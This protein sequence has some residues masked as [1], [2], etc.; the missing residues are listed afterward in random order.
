MKQKIIGLLVLTA[1]LLGLTACATRRDSSA[2]GAVYE[3]N[4]YTVGSKITTI[5]ATDGVSVELFLADGGKSGV[6][7][8]AAASGSTFYRRYEAVTIKTKGDQLT[9]TT[10]GEVAALRYGNADDLANNVNPATYSYTL[11]GQQKKVG[12][13][14]KAGKRVALVMGKTTWHLPQTQK[15]TRYLLPYGVADQAKQSKIDQE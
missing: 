14:T 9:L 7:A 15:R 13:L 11:D 3:A 6:L 10:T 1:A 12:T 2:M 8:T 5:K 4:Q